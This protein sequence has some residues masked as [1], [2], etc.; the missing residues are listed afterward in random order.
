MAHSWHPGG[1]RW[2]NS[3]RCLTLSSHRALLPPRAMYVNVCICLACVCALLMVASIAVMLQ[4]SQDGKGT[5]VG[6]RTM[7]FVMVLAG[8]GGRWPNSGLESVILPNHLG[9]GTDLSFLWLSS[10]HPRAGWFSSQ[11]LCHLDQSL[12]GIGVWF[13][14]LA[15]QSQVYWVLCGCPW[16]SEGK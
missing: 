7:G 8:A 12:E 9:I 5:L 1:Y 3:L 11:G 6:T 14:C 16:G 10:Y 13:P 2:E 15:L 4:S